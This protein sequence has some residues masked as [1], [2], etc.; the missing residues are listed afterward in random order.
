MPYKDKEKQKE[1]WREKKR[2]QRMSTQDDVHPENVQPN[3]KP[4]P[5]WV[6][7]VWSKKWLPPVDLSMLSGPQLQALKN[8]VRYWNEDG[9]QPDIEPD[10]EKLALLRG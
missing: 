1:Y 4:G 7:G 8:M 6:Y 3:G 2:Q 10:K 5:G 9:S